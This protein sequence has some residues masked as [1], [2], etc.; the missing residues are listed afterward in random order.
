MKLYSDVEGLTTEK[1][2]DFEVK[3]H[4][5]VEFQKIIFHPIDL[6]S[7]QDLHRESLNSETNCF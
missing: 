5:E 7:E 2:I 1:T 6:K 4:L 3:G